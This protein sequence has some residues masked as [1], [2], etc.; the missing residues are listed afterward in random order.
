[1]GTPVIVG[2]LL[3]GFAQAQTEGRQSSIRKV[4]F[5][6][7]LRARYSDDCP[8]PPSLDS[9]SFAD[10][11]GDGRE[12]ALVVASSC[13]TGTA[14]P[15]IHSVFALAE[16]EQVRELAVDDDQGRFEGKRIY[17]T[18]V[19]N[20]NHSLEYDAGFLV[21]RFTD[22]SGRDRPL[23]LF[24]RWNGHSFTLHAVERARTYPASFDCDNSQS[25]A[26]KTICGHSDL[27][28]ADRQLAGTV[29]DLASRLPAADKLRLQKEQREWL[30]LRDRCTY[31][32]VDEC[33]REAYR[34]RLTALKSYE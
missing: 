23:T 8:E 12:E 15:D 4:D 31:K 32:W 29:A 27:A 30:M 6:A 11:N 5:A 2:V 13:F 3:V 9:V 17:D 34:E 33:V 10:V 18:L 19:G 26:E 22:G 16:S 28:E 7:Y 25:D 24:F 21:K 1:M 20:R 14:G